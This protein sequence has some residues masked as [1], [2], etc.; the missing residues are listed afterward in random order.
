MKKRLR[1]ESDEESSSSNKVARKNGSKTDGSTHKNATCVI[2]M[3]S[4]ILNLSFDIVRNMFSKALP[5]L[6]K[7]LDDK[8]VSSIHLG[9]SSTHIYHH[10]MLLHVLTKNNYNMDKVHNTDY[11]SM[12]EISDGAFYIAVSYTH[13]TLPTICS[14]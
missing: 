10:N 11:L 8:D 1:V 12:F 7:V 9:D 13:L 5:E 3:V 4:Y 2:F 6:V 14:V